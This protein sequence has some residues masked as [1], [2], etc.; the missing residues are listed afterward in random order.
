MRETDLI[1]ALCGIEGVLTVK[2][3]RIS[4]DRPECRRT[5]SGI[6]IPPHAIACCGTVE[7]TTAE[8]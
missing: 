3:L 4:A 7:L 6:Q 8:R 5:S 1:A 2:Y